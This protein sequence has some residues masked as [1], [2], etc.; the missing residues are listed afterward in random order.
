MPKP[1]D[2]INSP[3]KYLLILAIIVMSV[4]FLSRLPDDS[5]LERRIREFEY[6]DSPYVPNVPETVFL[7]IPN[8]PDPVIIFSEKVPDTTR[9][10]LPSYEIDCDTLIS[11]TILIIMRGKS[12]SV[13]GETVPL[14]SDEIC[15]TFFK[16]S[17]TFFFY[18]P[19]TITRGEA[20]PL[21][22]ETTITAHRR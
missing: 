13:I 2:K 3:A 21:T 14:P 4:W 17:D 22:A 20:I 18:T 6:P 9:C 5:E 11:D 16:A 15:D 19:S 7:Y 1:K 8:M 12:I 10:V